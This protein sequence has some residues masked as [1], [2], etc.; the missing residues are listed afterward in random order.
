ML[1]AILS[2]IVVPG[3]ALLIAMPA[4]TFAESH[5][6]GGSYVERHSAHR[7]RHHQRH[8]RQHRHDRRH[9]RRVYHHRRHHRRQEY[10]GVH[11][12][13]HFEGHNHRPWY[14][15]GHAYHVHDNNCPVIIRPVIVAPVWDVYYHSHPHRSAAAMLQIVVGPFGGALYIDDQYYGEAHRLHD[16]RIELPVSPGLHSVQ[17]RHG[18]RTYSQQVRAKRGVTAIVKANKR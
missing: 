9:A 6:R 4:P 12:D 15:H 1:K 17:L 11:M 2:S 5:P 8:Y 14:P 16:G 7:S 3:I 10:H 18:G 13:L